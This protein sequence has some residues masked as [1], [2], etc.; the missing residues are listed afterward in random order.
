MLSNKVNDH[1]LFPAVS[2]KVRKMMS[3]RQHLLH[4]Q[5]VLVS[6]SESKIREWLIGAKHQQCQPMF[7]KKNVA[8]DTANG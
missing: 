6:L 3:Q 4:Q 5:I 1:R 8:E 7:D 2:V